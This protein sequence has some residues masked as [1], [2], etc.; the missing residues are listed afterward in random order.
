[1]TCYG[2]AGSE[3]DTCAAYAQLAVQTAYERGF[4]AAE[5]VHPGSKL[6]Y[7]L[8]TVCCLEDVI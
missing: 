7:V 5:K 1:M 2:A 6:C 4:G 8:H 3:A